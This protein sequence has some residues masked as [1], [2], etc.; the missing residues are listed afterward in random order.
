MAV[1][2]PA[3]DSGEASDF[4]Q[5]QAQDFYDAEFHNVDDENKDDKQN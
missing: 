1:T 5:Q 4:N 2:L 3:P